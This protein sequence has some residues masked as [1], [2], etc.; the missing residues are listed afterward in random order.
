MKSTI[1]K[2]TFQLLEELNWCSR[3]EFAISSLVWIVKYSMAL[4]EP[5][6]QEQNFFLVI[7]GCFAWSVPIMVAQRWIKRIPQGIQFLW[8]K[9]LQKLNLD[10]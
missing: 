6:I 5:D 8:I 3:T 2:S 9:L 10:K 4:N 7:L 1:K